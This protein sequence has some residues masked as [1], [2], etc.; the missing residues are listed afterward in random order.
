MFL[1]NVITAATQVSIL[2]ILVGVG[3]ITERLRVFEEKTAKALTTLLFHIVTPSV[4]I[5]SFITMEFTQEK[6]KGFATAFLCIFATYVISIFLIIPFFRNKEVPEN[7]VYKFAA[8]YGNMGYMA[9]PLAGAVLGPEGVFYCS[10]GVIVFNIFAFT[11]GIWLLNKDNKNSKFQLKSLFLNPGVISVV[12]GLPLFIFSVNVPLIIKQPIAY[13]GSLN[14]PLAMLILGTYI[15]RTDLRSI[16]KHSRQYLVVAFK[17]VAIPLL[18]LAIFKL[19]GISGVLLTACVISSSAPSANN[20]VI[21]A[22]KYNKDTGTASRTVAFVSF[23]SIIT[24]PLMIAL[25]KL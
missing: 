22:A 3:F 4:I 23:I 24:M 7:V 19:V 5:N 13:M 12:I 20:T 17:L 10:A 1:D 8:V 21:F 14:T 9:L 25:S 16:F 15:S 18:M 11:H 2:Y 6:A